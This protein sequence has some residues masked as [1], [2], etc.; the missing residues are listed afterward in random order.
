MARSTVRIEPLI[1]AMGVTS[2]AIKQAVRASQRK[3][4]HR[5]FELRHGPK[6][7]GMTSGTFRLRAL[8]DVVFL[9]TLLTVIADTR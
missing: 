8:V 5:M 2:F 1:D 7:L 4:S 9:M 6:L 3:T